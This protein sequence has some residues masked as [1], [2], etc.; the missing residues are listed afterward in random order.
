VN[1]RMSVI[2]RAAVTD[3]L[4]DDDVTLDVQLANDAIVSHA[5]APQAELVMSQGL[6]DLARVGARCDSM[7][8][9]SGTLS[10]E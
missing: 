10:M 9:S 3:R 4:H 2:Y 5:V 6:A 1:G 7:S 8:G